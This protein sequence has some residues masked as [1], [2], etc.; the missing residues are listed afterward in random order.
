MASLGVPNQDGIGLF[1]DL[2]I[3]AMMQFACCIKIQYLSIHHATNI[4]CH[5]TCLICLYR[6]TRIQVKMCLILNIHWLYTIHVS[7]TAKH[8]P[9]LTA[10]LIDF[11]WCLR[12]NYLLH[13]GEQVTAFPQADF[14]M[15]INFN[16]NKNKAHR[17]DN[18]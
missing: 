7:W 10:S 16:N 11:M 9:T 8:S 6:N 5:T 15:A 1:E 13:P 17:F 12:P 14:S 18:H 4:P 3:T 2:A